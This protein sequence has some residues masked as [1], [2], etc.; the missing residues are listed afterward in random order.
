MLEILIFLILLVAFNLMQFGAIRD[1]L[2]LSHVG[3]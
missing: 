3:A 1:L 2:I